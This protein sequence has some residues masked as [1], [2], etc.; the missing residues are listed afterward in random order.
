MTVEPYRRVLA[1]PG[2][3]ALLLVGLVARIPVTATG[4]TLTLHV[5]NNLKLGFFQA[6]LV[7]AA[8]TV[9]T[10][11]GAPVAGRFMDRHGLRPIVAVTTVAQF[12][13]WVSAPFLPY[14]LLLAGAVLGGVLS[15]PVFGLIRQ[16]M[17]AA[18]PPEQRR[19]GYALDSMIV[20]VAYMIGPALAVAFATTFGS[21]WSMSAVGVG[22]VGSGVAMLV[23]NP[24]TR[25]KGDEA[26]GAVVP[27]RQWLTP[28][29]LSLLGL[30]FAATFV[31]IA[32]ELSLVAVLTA[33]DAARWT[34][35]AIGLWCFWSIV[36]GFVYGALPRGFSPL[37]MIGAMAALTVPVGLIG[38][39]QLLCVA[40]I[41]AGILCAPALSTTID[42]LSQWVPAVA[43]GEAMGLHGTA[44]TLGL[45][46]SGPITG[47]IIDTY[48]TRW[49]FAFAGLAGLFFVTVAIPFWR[50]IPPPAGATVPEPAAA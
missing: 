8:A 45:A 12:A 21:G 4:L 15:L 36:G 16:C 25:A 35:L 23:L 14:A 42:T 10:A 46:V 2:V 30:T 20:E 44:L 26:L 32:T 34:G 17:A 50:R 22:M 38:S 6:G 43:R 31:L 48:G 11:V 13:F 49:S 24:P 41:P 47:H 3:R 39:W 5:L 9:G 33:D 18:V 29:L 40:M 19:T 1:I 27:R 7:G 28:A 37:V